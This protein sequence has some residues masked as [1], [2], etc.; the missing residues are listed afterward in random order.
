MKKKK[1]LKGYREENVNNKKKKKANKC[2]IE[3]GH[4][5]PSL[6]VHRNFRKNYKYVPYLLG[7]VRLF[8]MQAINAVSRRIFLDKP[9]HFSNHNHVLCTA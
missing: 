5:S 6:C 1:I 4:S 3:E 7:N 2:G 9:C 8:Y